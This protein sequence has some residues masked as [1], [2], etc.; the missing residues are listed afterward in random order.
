MS[1]ATAG[2][3]SPSV[4]SAAARAALGRTALPDLSRLKAIIFDVDGTL[5]RQG[6]LRRLMLLRLL[7]AHL[8]RPRRGYA[9]LKALRAYRNAQEAMRQGDQC[10]GGGDL[11]AQQLRLACARAGVEA[12]AMAACVAR[13]MEQEP[14]DLLGGALRAGVF[15]LLRAAK[16]RGLR[17]GVCS[18][19]PASRKLAAMRLANFFEVVVSAQ[20]SEVRRFKPDPRGLEVALQRLGVAPHEALYVGDR[21]ETDAVAARRAGI[22]C[23]IV[24]DGHRRR[25]NTDGA[26]QVST[27]LELRD[28]LCQQHD[29]LR[30]PA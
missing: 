22:S 13:W 3:A 20:D 11:A 14:L 15:E 9:T 27:L 16:E 4:A 17:L 25:A 8:T 21:M 2:D 26:A 28:A 5:Y 10:G 19:Y 1:A 30:R 18:D 24:G 6:R 12:D 29:E 7:K 23:V